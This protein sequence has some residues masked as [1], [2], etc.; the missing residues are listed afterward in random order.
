MD[1]PPHSNSVNSSVTSVV[2]TLG[3]GS[4]PRGIDAFPT[5]YEELK[6]LAH[7]Q[8]NKESPG[9]GRREF[10]TTTIVSEAC[11][12]LLGNDAPW[13]N[14][15]HFYGAAARAMRHILVDAA[16][17]RAV[18]DKHASALALSA[19][20]DAEETPG[21]DHQLDLLALD[22]ALAELETTYPKHAE[23]VSL[24]FF[25]GLTIV[26]TAQALGVDPKTVRNRWDF[27]RAWLYQRMNPCA[28]EH[29]RNK[30][31]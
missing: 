14:R 19:D 15:A 28:D 9:G 2:N 13:E 10:Q 5:I 7:L 25:A 29:G 20:S 23:V 31:A 21:G 8:L 1:R 16:R 11:V 12:R 22:S 30:P 26:E 17:R 24:R 27:A 6:R 4:N 3:K 18:R